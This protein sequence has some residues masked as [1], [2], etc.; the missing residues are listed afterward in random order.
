METLTIRSRIFQKGSRSKG[1]RA[2]IPI[3]VGLLQPKCQN[4]RVVFQFHKDLQVQTTAG[5]SSEL[6]ESAKFW[7]Q[8]TSYDHN[9]SSTVAEALPKSVSITRTPSSSSG[10]SSGSSMNKLT[11]LGGISIVGGGNNSGSGSANKEPSADKPVSKPASGSSESSLSRLT[12][13]NISV[14]G[15]GGSRKPSTDSGKKTA[16]LFCFF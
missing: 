1:S 15:G 4:C 12:A 2:A 6:L 13:L 11:Q 9:F 3:Q 16:L 5:E 10:G 14:S 7:C 8:V